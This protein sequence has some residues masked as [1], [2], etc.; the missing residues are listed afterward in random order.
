[1]GGSVLS[2]KRKTD[3]DADAFLHALKHERKEEI[4][5]V[6]AIIRAADQKLVERIKWNAPSYGYDDDRITF[7]L[8]PKNVVHLVFHRGAKKRTDSFTF[9]D[10]T[11]LLDWLAGDRAVVKFDDMQDV[12]GKK[13]K[14]AKLV[15][16]WMKATN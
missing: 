6:R 10:E 5:A 3:S 8:H 11:G 7:R 16:R 15:A 12:R 14:L 1:M 13:T 2:A 4:E 9:E